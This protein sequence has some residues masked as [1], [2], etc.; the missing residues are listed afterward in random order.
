MCRGGY[1]GGGIA[2]GVSNSH[3]KKTLIRVRGVCHPK[4]SS[5]HH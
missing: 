5:S 2:W 1:W 3:K 4:N